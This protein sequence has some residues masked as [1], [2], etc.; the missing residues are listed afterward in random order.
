M[1]VMMS[2][3]SEEM[4]NPRYQGFGQIVK[5]PGNCYTEI[6]C[7]RKL[8]TIK[9][10]THHESGIFY[11]DDFMWLNDAGKTAVNI[12]QIRNAPIYLARLPNIVLLGFIR[13]IATCDVRCER[14]Q[15]LKQ[16]LQILQLRSTDK[17]PL[18]KPH[19]FRSAC[20]RAYSMIVGPVFAHIQSH[21]YRALLLSYS[22]A[23]DVPGD[24]ERMIGEFLSRRH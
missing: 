11:W 20:F 15:V 2:N 3:I 21:P 5:I 23:M 24:I 17:R 8:T 12:Y 6:F 9:T 1:S 10:P 22:A 7:D 14:L 4:G 13:G 19:V 16:V 18:I